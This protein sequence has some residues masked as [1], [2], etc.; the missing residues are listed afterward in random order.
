MTDFPEFE[1]RATYSPEDDK[2]RLYPATDDKWPDAVYKAYKAAGLG[3]APQQHFM[4]G[5]WTPG[6][7]DLFLAWGG[8]DIEDEDV[9]V[10]ERAMARA[11]RFQ[12]YQAKRADEAHERHA[13]AEQVLSR[14][15]FGQPMMIGHHSY[16][17]AKRDAER[18]ENNLRRAVD[19]FSTADYWHWRARGVIEHAR[20]RDV[21]AVV[22]R[23]IKGLEADLRKYQKELTTVM[24]WRF[25]ESQISMREHDWVMAC[26]K[27]RREQRPEPSKPDE[28]ETL[29][30]A[31]ELLDRHL[32]GMQRWIEHIVFRLQFENE[33]YAAQVGQTLAEVGQQLEPGC[34]VWFDGCWRIVRKVNKG[35]AGI[36]SVSVL[37]LKR[38]SWQRDHETVGIDKIKY[39]R[40]RAQ[41]ETGEFPD[42]WR[43][44]WRAKYP[45][46]VEDDFPVEG[47]GYYQVQVKERIIERTSTSADRATMAQ[48]QQV[49]KEGIKIKQVD[50]L[51]ETPEPVIT[52][53]LGHMAEKAPGGK[54]ILLGSPAAPV[55]V[56]EM[57]AGPGAILRRLQPYR[58]NLAIDWC[59]LDWDLHQQLIALNLGTDAAYDFL[60][61]QPLTKRYQFILGNPP[62]KHHIDARHVAH[63]CALLAEG[64]RLISIMSRMSTQVDGFR[65]LFGNGNPWQLIVNQMLPPETFN[66]Q[67]SGVQVLTN[68]VVIDRVQP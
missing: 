27:A 37:R 57:G 65:L 10:E 28:Q 39:Q 30:W 5:T 67:E 9:S 21:P 56:L 63:G 45:D 6:R 3:W 33:V 60:E 15:P 16:G 23:R 35:A 48:A 41:V 8:G 38:E 61:Y 49:L 43:S 19:A 46:Q 7:E 22:A 68:L 54:L 11:D 34:Q 12:D 4:S 62:F 1:G 42:D 51:V 64:G 52:L 31:S 14:I 20:R 44:A 24:C 13:M 55:S 17:K 59:E 40:S 25:V 50:Q 47:A 2:L 18:I 66:L 36:S 58:S 32:I 53:M 29:L 26:G